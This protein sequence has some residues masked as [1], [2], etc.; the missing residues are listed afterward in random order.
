MIKVELEIHNGAV[1]ESPKEYEIIFHISGA[2]I[3]LWLESNM[4]NKEFIRTIIMFSDR[5]ADA[6]LR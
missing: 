4:S 3:S 5:I 6:L 2:K 1:A